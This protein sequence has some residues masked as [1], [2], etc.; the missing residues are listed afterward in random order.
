MQGLRERIVAEEVRLLTLTGTAGTGKTRLATAL[1]QSLVDAFEDGVWFVDLAPIDDPTGVVPAIGRALGLRH[2]AGEQM[3]VESLVNFLREK[4]LLL[5]LDNFEQVL[6]AAFD[7]GRL[8]DHSP[9]LQIVATS[10]EPLRLRWERLY[11]VPPLRVPAAE[12]D[13]AELLEVPAVQLF[14]QRAREVHPDF[15][16]TST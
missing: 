9:L 14:V 15:E 2:Q 4:R 11:P 13:L 8:L 1:G 6:D 3:G 7:V 10:R 5:V 12:A 16:V